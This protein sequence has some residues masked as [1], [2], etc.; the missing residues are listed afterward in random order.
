AVFAQEQWTRDRLSLQAAV[1]L[2]RAGSWFPEQRLGLSRFL[3]EPIVV[4]ETR[5]VDSYADMSPRLGVVYD[6]TGKGRTAIKMSIG[7]Y[8]E[9]AGVQGIYANTTPTLRMPQTTM[10]FGTAGVTR[11]WIDEN[12]D[13]VPDCDLAV[14]GAQDL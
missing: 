6:L 9:G 11:S 1:R 5:G 10:V 13:L 4:P 7:R 3:P 8:L 12:G 14:T 2:D